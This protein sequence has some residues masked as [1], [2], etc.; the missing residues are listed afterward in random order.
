MMGSITSEAGGRGERERERGRANMSTF[1]VGW[2]N[3]GQ[4]YDDR[5]FYHGILE[6]AGD[7]KS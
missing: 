4:T 5:V 2:T 6:K 3:F 1:Y 7:E